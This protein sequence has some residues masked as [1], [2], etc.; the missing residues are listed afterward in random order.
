MASPLLLP[1]TRLNVTHRDL[2][3]HT[4]LVSDLDSD[5]GADID[6]LLP[7]V[8]TD[9]VD[10]PPSAPAATEARVLNDIVEEA[11]ELLE[12]ELLELLAKG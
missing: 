8:A 1:E 4:L 5:A 11:A 3:D 9:Y 7:L 12:E 10:R 6:L 2:V